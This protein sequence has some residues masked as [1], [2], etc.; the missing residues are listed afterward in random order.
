MKPDLTPT[1]VASMPTVHLLYGLAGSGKTTVARQLEIALP[2]IRF[3]L[4][5]WMLRFDPDLDFDST[6]YAERADRVREL[7]WSIAAQVLSQGGNVVLDWNSW[8]VQRRTW[9]IERAG[10]VGATVVLHRLHTSLADATE[11]AR[12][13]TAGDVPWTHDI[14][15]AGNEHLAALLEEPSTAEGMSIVHH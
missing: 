2:A 6:A 10:G 3:T 7:I 8:S 14:T 4:D 11:R 5:E 1:T 15:L 12:T 9:A 13:R